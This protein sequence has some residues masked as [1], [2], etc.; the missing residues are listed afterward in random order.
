MDNTTTIDRSS[1]SRSPFKKRIIITIGVGFSLGIVW[2]LTRNAYEKELTD[3]KDELN[4]LKGIKRTQTEESSSKTDL[5]LQKKT[6]E[7]FLKI[8]DLTKE[9]QVLE[10]QI[11]QQ[12][13]EA[14][15][16]TKGKIEK[17]NKQIKQKRDELTAQLQVQ[18]IRIKELEAKNK[19]QIRDSQALKTKAANAQKEIK[20]LQRQLQKVEK[21]KNESK[22]SGKKFAAAKEVE[23]KQLQRQLQ[24]AQKEKNESK[25]SRKK[26]A[27]AKEVEIKELKRQ[28]QQAQK[29][30]NESKDSGK[31]F[32][33]KKEKE[34]KQLKR[35]LQQA[36]QKRDKSKDEIEI[37]LLKDQYNK[38]KNQLNDVTVGKGIESD[39]IKEED[40][41]TKKVA[42]FIAQTF[43]NLFDDLYEELEE[44]YE[45]LD[46]AAS[47]SE[48][49]EGE[50]D[51]VEKVN[52]KT[53]FE[54]L[55][56]RVVYEF[57]F[58]LLMLC[59]A[60]MVERKSKFCQVIAKQMN[61]K[62]NK[63]K[64]AEEIVETMFH[65][66][67][68]QQWQDYLKNK[69]ENIFGIEIDEKDKFIDDIFNCIC[70]NYKKKEI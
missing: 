31:K 19:K 51:D 10:G 41:N 17:I 1:T 30:K 25:D 8:N 57:L 47:S 4:R 9:K 59:R 20:Q 39:F 36:E 22:D 34:I 13:S 44:K 68:Q 54:S 61:I 2:F 69:M 60:S 65:P 6:A 37:K 7:L 32:A 45:K 18:D 5:E 53:K 43:K 49:S 27:A 21:E 23:I 24:Q 55:I 35:Q 46:E 26:F 15:S 63:A 3:T 50:D 38:L 42:P 52:T 29:E 28:L 33:K 11:Q 40:F 70:N 62:D 16:K 67:L 64:K 58:D 66:Q 48:E 12:A 14:N 56:D